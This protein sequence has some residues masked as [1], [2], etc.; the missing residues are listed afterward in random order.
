MAARD[1]AACLRVEYLDRLDA[2]QLVG[3]D[4]DFLE[5]LK[6]EGPQVWA[7]LEGCQAAPSAV[8]V[9]NSRSAHALDRHAP[10]RHAL[11]SRIRVA[12]IST[13]R[14]ALQQR[15][16]RKLIFSSTKGLFDTMPEFSARNRL[17]ST[18]GV[19]FGMFAVLAAEFF[20]LNFATALFATHVAA[21]VFFVG[22]SGLRIAA[23]IGGSL[24]SERYQQPTR[25]EPVYSVLIALW[26]E[27]NMIPQLL[28]ALSRLDWPRDR[29][30]I[31]LIC[32]EDDPATIEAI[33]RNPLHSL[34]ETIVVPPCQPRT[35]PKA[36]RYAMSMTRGEFVVL[37]DAEDIP[38]PG[39]LRE[40][41]AAFE[42]ASDNLACL[43]APLEI[44]NGEENWITRCF[45]FEY[46]ALFRGLVPWLASRNLVFPLGGTSNH[47]RRS[48]LEAAG[49]WDP[50][51]VTEDADLGIRLGRMGY[52]I[53]TIDSP[54]YETA[55]NRLKDW[56]PQRARWN[57]GWMQTWLVHMRSPILLARELGAG[58]FI[59]AQFVLFGMVFSSLLHPMV[60]ALIPYLSYVL[61]WSVPMG[62]WETALITVD[63]IS[64]VGGYFGFLLLGYKRSVGV[65]RQSFWRVAVATP[66]Y[67][68]AISAAAWKALKDLWLNPFHWDKTSHDPFSD[69][70][71]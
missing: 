42:R 11:K 12:T 44:I 34:V 31:K 47:F 21:T 41:F 35:K 61:L 65:E 3:R 7:T 33:A 70:Q 66:L 53:G 68:L 49:A 32:E 19:L 55:P 18:Q 17:S 13:V 60:L 5:L 2:S 4:E 38:H 59:V 40:A 36:L 28:A 58:S 23:A 29:L 10:E 16:A 25:A 52:E 15:L 43:Q 48:A 54:T 69:S 56:Y 63:I 64:I 8:V 1:L 20:W 26:R 37:Y 30:E 51:N 46:R 71:A 6:R 9:P 27:S 50:H 67:W 22:C 62:T 24:Q 45:A 14:K 57:K 39:Q